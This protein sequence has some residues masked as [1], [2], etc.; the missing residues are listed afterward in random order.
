MA[1]RQPRPIT[2]NTGA[3]ERRGDLA[4]PVRECSHQTLATG[5]RSYDRFSVTLRGQADAEPTF[6]R[7]VLRSGAVVGVL[8][9][10]F[11]RGEIVLTRQF[12]LGGHLALNRGAMV[13]IVAGRVDPGE[14]P[15]DA[16]RRECYE[17]IGTCPVT[18]KRL[19]EFCP[20]PA[21][22]DELMTLFLAHVD[23]SCASARGG[24]ANENEDITVIRYSI[25]EAI[26]MLQSCE[27]YSGP[28]IIALQ[29]LCRNCCR[30]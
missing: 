29:W 27:L 23:A 10:D 4:C 30:P 6:H 2:E 9:V 20:A 14:E 15:E 18:L 5:F 22:S 24:L 13:E 21:L 16:A 17:E 25:P 11:I 8:P 28:T 1:V 19:F 12:R 7:E 26:E 3:V